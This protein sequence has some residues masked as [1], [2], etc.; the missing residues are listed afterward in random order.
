MISDPNTMLA[1]GRPGLL[2]Q[3]EPGLFGP[4]EIPSP[5][6][7]KASPG[8]KTVLRGTRPILSWRD[9]ILPDLVNR[10]DN[11]DPSVRAVSSSEQ[12]EQTLHL[13]GAAQESLVRVEKNRERRLYAQALRR[14]PYGGAA[15][16]RFLSAE[17]EA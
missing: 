4:I 7:R 16:Q 12:E 5:R 1:T 14:N 6:Q 15:L 17:A 13:L 11:G 10:A 9:F 2:A 3:V 8:T